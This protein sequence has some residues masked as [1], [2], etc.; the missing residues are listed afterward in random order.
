[1]W[2]RVAQLL[3]SWS[4]RLFALAA[5][6]IALL[7]LSP[8]DVSAE[9]G[10]SGTYAEAATIFAQYTLDQRIRLQILLTAAGYWPA[11]PNADFNPRIFEALTRFQADHGFLTTGVLIPNQMDRLVSDASPFLNQSGFQK[12]LHPTHGGAIGCLS[13][14][15]SYNKIFQPA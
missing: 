2:R 7:P 12:V 6:E 3:R 4:L 9:M 11:V 14:W 8:A 13:A 15:A 1:M 5:I 10:A